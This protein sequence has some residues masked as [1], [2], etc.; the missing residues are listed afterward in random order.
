MQQI[1]HVNNRSKYHFAHDLNETK[2]DY[3]VQ[4]GFRDLYIL[5]AKI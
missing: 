5:V 4:Q 2:V 1:E 3:F